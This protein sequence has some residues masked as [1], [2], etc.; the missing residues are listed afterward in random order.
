[1]P[2]PITSGRPLSQNNKQNWFPV[3][4]QNKRFF[5]TVKQKTS[6][7]LPSHKQNRRKGGINKKAGLPYTASWLT[8]E[9]AQDGTAKQM[10]AVVQVADDSRPQQTVFGREQHM[11]LV[12]AESRARRVPC[13]SSYKQA[14]IRLPGGPRLGAAEVWEWRRVE[15]MI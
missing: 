2:S 6:A 8:T 10:I 1:L 4:K 12:A 14:L 9:L 3:F 15:P 13:S 7:Y 5:L 11:G